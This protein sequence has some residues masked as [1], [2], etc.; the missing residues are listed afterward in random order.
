MELL[1]SIVLPSVFQIILKSEQNIEFYKVLQEACFY[2]V[3]IT[4]DILS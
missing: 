4:M 2:A 3:D 1:V